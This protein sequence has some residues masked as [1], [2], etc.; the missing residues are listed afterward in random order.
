MAIIQAGTKVF[1]GKA[2]YYNVVYKHE[3]AH[4]FCSQDFPAEVIEGNRK[5]YQEPGMVT[6]KLPKNMRFSGFSGVG[7]VDNKDV[8]STE[9]AF[10]VDD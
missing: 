2:S 5:V 9:E 3:T 8:L 10:N 7:W 1:L 4:I 6:I